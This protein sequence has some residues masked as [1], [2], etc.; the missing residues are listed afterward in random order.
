VTETALRPTIGSIRCPDAARW[1]AYLLFL[2]LFL[3]YFLLIYL[4]V[5]ALVVWLGRSI[6]LYAAWETQIPLVPFMVWV[7]LSLYTIFALPL[8][9][10]TPN[11]M[12]QL[13]RQSTVTLL[14]AGIGF[15]AL[16]G[17]IGFP[18]TSY[19]GIEGSI[20]EFL[21]NL[22][23]TRHNLVP[24]L[25][26]AFSALILL[27]CRDLVS[28]ALSRFYGLWLALMCASTLLTHQH[29]LLDVATGLALAII[30]RRLL[31]LR[32][33]DASQPSR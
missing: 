18:A 24:S 32:R 2:G 9:H 4:G 1:R 6:S 33:D 7:Y 31:P 29:H 14:V 12:A 5:G 11:Q 16:P 26:V 13:S 8:L 28:P 27:G 23:A 19:T 22:S 25:H 20:L 17:Q 10:M 21:D 15:L 30:V 3:P